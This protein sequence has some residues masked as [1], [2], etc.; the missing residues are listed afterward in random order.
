MLIRFILFIVILVFLILTFAHL[1]CH[2]LKEFCQ[3]LSKCVSRYFFIGS[4]Y[5]NLHHLYTDSQASQSIRLY[6]DH[7]FFWNTWIAFFNPVFSLGQLQSWPLHVLSFWVPESFP[8]QNLLSLWWDYV[9]INPH[10]LKIL[11]V[12]NAFNTPHPPNIA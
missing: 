6:S 3:P 5:I 9:P 12:M 10:K 8:G 4:L 7:C 2:R 11:Y 1:I